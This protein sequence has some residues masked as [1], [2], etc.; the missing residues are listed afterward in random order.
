MKPIH[1]VLAGLLAFAAVAPAS[2]QDTFCPLLKR[3]IAAKAQRFAPL[4]TKPYHSDTREWD[5]RVKLPG[6]QFCRIDQE[7]A[8]FNCWV[9]GL[10]EEWTKEQTGQIKASLVACLGDPS[11]PE[12]SDE[13]AS[14]R[15]TGV[16][17]ENEGARIELITRIGKG[18]PEKHSIF[19]YVR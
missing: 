1:P 12:K 9:T 8:L 13:L 10:S 4:K 17:W 7:R 15:R 6:T 16:A 3:V 19:I 2:A 5:A 14:T 11:S 18:K